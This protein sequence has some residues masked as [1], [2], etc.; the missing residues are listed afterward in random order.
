MVLRHGSSLLGR[1]WGWGLDVGILP[2]SPNIDRY[3]LMYTSGSWLLTDVYRFWRTPMI[4]R[5]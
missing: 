5:V 3:C 2:P 1:G 4:Q